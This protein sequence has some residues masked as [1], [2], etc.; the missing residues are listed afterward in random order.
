MKTYNISVNQSYLSNSSKNIDIKNMSEL[1]ND[2]VDTIFFNCSEALS[3]EDTHKTIGLLLE[4][5]GLNGILNMEILCIFTYLEDF[6]KNKIT[7]DNFLQTM[8]RTNNLITLDN[9]ISCLDVQKHEMYQ[10]SYKDY[11][12]YLS[13]KKVSL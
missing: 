13:I 8:H 1:I 6:V 2:S 3:L 4:K 12:T 9:I 10:I 11:K 7:S 5:L